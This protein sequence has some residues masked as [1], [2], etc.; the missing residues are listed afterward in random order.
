MRFSWLAAVVV[1]HFLAGCGIPSRDNPQDSANAPEARLAVENT[2]GET[3]FAISRG[4][5]LF[6]DAS[7]SD[8]PQGT[9]G[10]H[11]EFGVLSTSG[12]FASG[13]ADAP[14]LG[15]PLASGLEN[16]VEV[17]EN[18]RRRVPPETPVQFRVIVRDAAGESCASTTVLLENAPPIR[19]SAAPVVLPFGGFPTRPG[20]DIVA[21]FRTDPVSDPDGDPVEYCWTFPPDAERCAP[22]P[23]G[24]RHA[25]TVDPT[26]SGR[27]PG[28][29]QTRDDAHLYSAPSVAVATVGAPPLWAAHDQSSVERIDS[30]RSTSDVDLIISDVFPSLTTIDRSHLAVFG[31][32]LSAPESLRV[33]ELPSFT[34]VDELSLGIYSSFAIASD[35]QRIWGFTPF[36]PEAIFRWSWNGDS[37]G[38]I[39]PVSAPAPT[40]NQPPIVRAGYFSDAWMAQYRSSFVL[41]V[42]E[43]LTFER[44]DT[45]PERIVT[46]FDVRPQTKELWAIETRDYVGVPSVEGAR[47][48]RLV[49]G[50]SG[51]AAV[52]SIPLDA[53]Y[54]FALT[55]ASES[56]FWI[57]IPGSGLLLLD[58][59]RLL[60]TGNVALATLL[61]FDVPYVDRLALDADTGDVWAQ[62][63]QAF[64]HA[65]RSG[66]LGTYPAAGANVLHADPE[67]AIWYSSNVSSFRIGRALCGADAGVC[68]Q[69]PIGLDVKGSARDPATGGV[70]LGRQRGTPSGLTLVAADGRIRETVTRVVDEDGNERPVP[71][72]PILSSSHEGTSLW[73]LAY[74]DPMSNE[75]TRLVHLDVTQIPPRMTDVVTD[76]GVVSSLD[77]GYEPL[78][79]GTG[80]AWMI[81]VDTDEIVVITTAGTM[82]GR[83]S[84]APGGAQGDQYEIAISRETNDLYLAL[85]TGTDMEL[86]VIPPSGTYTGPLATFAL[87]DPPNQYPQL[88]VNGPGS[89]WVAYGSATT[90]TIAGYDLAGNPI[91]T[92]IVVGGGFIWGLAAPS[93]DEIWM[94]RR[95]AAQIPDVSTKLRIDW[96]G[97]DWTT[98]DFG[99]T[100]MHRLVR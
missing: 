74:E 60:D 37:L 56:E 9:D 2:A 80:L 3:V 92:P 1:S 87:S 40:S 63:G 97:L 50:T 65:M 10:L 45:P 12:V 46:G 75:P 16:R 47:V 29:L 34:V 68:S 70:W 61:Q 32:G 77:L 43:D 30:L 52:G 62:Y 58:A 69:L 83:Y 96:D 94:T 64:I 11:F 13:C 91:H 79:A 90:T 36:E 23:L 18:F 7:E 41:H 82:T 54:A 71:Q 20:T 89:I 51:I 72:L 19:A 73:G 57:S 81:D 35:G 21:V 24:L 88:V 95:T 15:S 84:F 17:P 55:W 8:D 14:A 85:R 22:A 42:N 67:G 25:V 49:A 48:V 78:H 98:T 99:A 39:T 27:L 6:L 31:K 93:N 33:I 44:H 100:G 86:W 76:L 26:V 5:A 28:T 38:A 59:D 4:A 53:D 66:D